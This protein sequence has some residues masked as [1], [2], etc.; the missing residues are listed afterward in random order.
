MAAGR[1]M[2]RQLSG[3]SR[4]GPAGSIEKLEAADSKLTSSDHFM[5]VLGVIFLLHEC[6]HVSKIPQRRT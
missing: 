4:L 3:S 2:K 5:P 1:M 6:S